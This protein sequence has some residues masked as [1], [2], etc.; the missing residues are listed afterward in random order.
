MIVNLQERIQHDKAV[1]KHTDR[2]K[3]RAF[4]YRDLRKAVAG[5]RHF[6]GLLGPVSDWYCI[7]GYEGSWRDTGDPYWGGLQMDKSFMRAY[8]PDM[9][10]AYHGYA[11]VWLPLDQ[12]I[13]AER[14]RRSR[15]FF[16]WP[17]TA[18]YCHLI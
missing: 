2:S 8:G 1:L 18:H 6:L 11:N 10:H 3:T 17:N 16:P 5:L 15:G 12:I 13:V 4:H 14:A 7:H 9:L